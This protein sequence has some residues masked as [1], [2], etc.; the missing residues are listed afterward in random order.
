MTPG[1]HTTPRS[2]AIRADRPERSHR[3]QRADRAQRS[4]RIERAHRPQRAQSDH[5]PHHQLWRARHD[6]LH[7]EVR[8]ARRAHD[9][10]DVQRH[11]VR[12]HRPAGRRR[13]LGVRRVR[14][15][16]PGDGLG[17][18][19][20]APQ[21]HGPAH[22]HLPGQPGGA[23][24]RAR[25]ALPDAGERV[26]RQHLRQPAQGVLLQRLRLG[27]RAGVGPHRRQPERQA[28]RCIR[29]LRG[30]RAANVAHRRSRTPCL[31]GCFFVRLRGFVP[32]WL[33]Q[34]RG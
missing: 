22:R 7:R 32:S 24:S 4:H 21:H 1:A 30:R 27:S 26:L 6:L 28:S 8:A 17:V 13:G 2:R 33:R 15:A 3:A 16:L 9:H 10:Q 25:S 19:D 20:G 12:V 11:D 29:P 5:W 34:R 14:S 23:R 31:R 18:R